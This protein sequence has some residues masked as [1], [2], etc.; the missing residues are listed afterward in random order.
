MLLNI[1][2]EDQNELIGFVNINEKTTLAEVR[3]MIE[4]ELEGV[5][6]NFRFLIKNEQNWVKMSIIQES[7]N[8]AIEFMPNL[9]IK[10]CKNNSLLNS[11]KKNFNIKYINK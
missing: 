9:I 5:P 4:E 2:L 6:N 10:T 7:K 11:N 3:K 1:F 8:F